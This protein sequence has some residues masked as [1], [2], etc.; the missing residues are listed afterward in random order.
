[1]PRA[2]YRQYRRNRMNIEGRLTRVWLMLSIIW[3]AITG[4]IF[5]DRIKSPPLPLQ[6][7]RYFPEPRTFVPRVDETGQVIWPEP[8]EAQD[9]REFRNNLILYIPSQLSSDTKKMLERRFHRRFVVARD[10]EVSVKRQAHIW[11]FMR[12]AFIPPLA[13]FLVGGALVWMFPRTSRTE[14]E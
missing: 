13:L 14:V 6:E 7:Y 12:A 1:M 11:E 4:S 5:F 10:V 8:A 9:K 3:I 2:Y